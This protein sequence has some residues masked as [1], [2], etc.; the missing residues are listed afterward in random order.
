[1][2][3]TQLNEKELINLINVCG[4]VSRP[5]ASEEATYL[6]NLISKLSMMINELKSKP[7]KPV[8]PKE[9]KK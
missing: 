9:L 4:S 2:I 3:T 5:V 6:R 1:M 8:K 7:V